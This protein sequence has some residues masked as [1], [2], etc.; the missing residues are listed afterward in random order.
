MDKGQRHQSD[1][2]TLLDFA[3][4]IAA[5]LRLLVLLPLAAALAAFGLSFLAS[6]TYRATTQ[7]LVSPAP[8]Y[9]A[10]VYVTLLKSQ[11]MLDALARRFDLTRHYGAIDIEAARA[12]LQK[13][14]IVRPARISDVITLHVDDNNA[15]QA[16]DLANGYIEELRGL[17]LQLALV[18]ASKRRVFYESKLNAARLHLREAEKS[19]TDGAKQPSAMGTLSPKG[20][21]HAGLKAAVLFQVI[22]LA[23]MR[24]TM[25]DSNP[26]F[27]LEVQ[28]L[29]DLRNRLERYETNAFG[30]ASDRE[31]KRLQ[32]RFHQ[33][34]VDLIHQ[35]YEIARNEEA[36]QE[37]LFPV[38]DKALVPSS[39]FGPQRVRWAVEAG[40]VGLAVALLVMLLRNTLR[41][42]RRSPE[43]PAKQQQL[44]AALGMKESKSSSRND[45]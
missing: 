26:E 12:I 11:T 2:S 41:I 10:G 24:A 30:G 45:A 36:V 33:I 22:K 39:P 32:L 4:L 9:D 31:Q 6:P 29:V 18:E 35:Q 28:K 37:A 3:L 40:L 27:R 20:E 21:E 14:T 25:P 16:A 7:V 8:G 44:R 43:Y 17:A 13:R 19:L 34:V 38:I 15:K 23:A 1:E 5:N 42:A